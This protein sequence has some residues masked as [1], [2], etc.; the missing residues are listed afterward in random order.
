MLGVA[1]SLYF[2]PFYGPK[3]YAQKRCRPKESSCTRTGDAQWALRSLVALAQGTHSGYCRGRGPRTWT[4][5]RFA[6]L[7]F[8]VSC[9][10]CSFSAV[11][12][13]RSFGVGPLLKF[14]RTFISLSTPFN[15]FRTPRRTIEKTTRIVVGGSYS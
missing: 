10:G 5:S 13:L 4:F 3:F 7:R 14:R 6:F 2:Y 1:C 8:G 15:W 12:T 9:S 11:P